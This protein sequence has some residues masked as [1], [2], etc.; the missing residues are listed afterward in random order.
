MTYSDH[1]LFLFCRELGCCLYYKDARPVVG[2][3]SLHV[4]VFV[5]RLNTHVVLEVLGIGQKGWD[6]VKDLG[7]DELCFPVDLW[8]KPPVLDP[9][10]SRTCSED[11]Y[12]A[13]VSLIRAYD[14]N[15]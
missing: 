12:S 2:K 4:Q 10:I 11:L 8:Y 6:V 1:W 13:W 9:Q 3:I 5:P 15:Y 14:M 7:Y